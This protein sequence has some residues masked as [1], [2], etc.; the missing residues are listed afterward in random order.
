MYL[1]SFSLHDALPLLGPSHSA[2][3]PV[4]GK[5]SRNNTS[6]APST[7]ASTDSPAVTTRRSVR[8][9]RSRSRNSP[10]APPNAP[11]ISSATN[12]SLSSR[13]RSTPIPISSNNADSRNAS[14]SVTPTNAHEAHHKTILDQDRKSTRLNS[15]N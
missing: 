3:S 5:A 7:G 6:P 13:S 10:S 4:K 11:P 8:T 1:H 12:H 9:T 14:A 2:P 15:S